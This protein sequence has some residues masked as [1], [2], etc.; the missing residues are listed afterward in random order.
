MENQRVRKSGLDAQDW[1]ANIAF[2]IKEG[3]GFVALRFLLVCFFQSLT[4][5]SQKQLALVKVRMI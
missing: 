1:F 5:P 2:E 4:Q 3:K